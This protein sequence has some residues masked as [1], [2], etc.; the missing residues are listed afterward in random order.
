MSNLSRDQQSANPK[1]RA[2]TSNPPQA[3][4]YT[5]QKTAACRSHSS[6][7]T[8]IASPST[9]ARYTAAHPEWAAI[10][11]GGTTERSCEI[12]Q[13]IDA[14]RPQR[15]VRNRFCGDFTGHV[16]FPTDRSPSGIRPKRVSTAVLSLVGV[17]SG[18]DTPDACPLIPSPTL[19]VP[20][21]G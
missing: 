19:R 6:Q 5:Q 14:H 21:S 15:N 1:T 11:G 12:P 9:E 20:V 7:A 13:L 16:E 18:K 4:Q 10:A 2:Y 3:E 17:S 8:K